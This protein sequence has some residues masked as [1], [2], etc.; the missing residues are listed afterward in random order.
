M[1]LSSGTPIS[2]SLLAPRTT[3]PF[4]SAT[5]PDG[6]PSCVGL[7]GMA[8]PWSCRG[9]GRA[10]AVL[11][12]LTSSRRRCPR[13]YADGPSPFCCD[14]LGFLFTG[15][16][17]LPRLPPEARSSGSPLTSAGAFMFCS[18]CSVSHRDLNPLRTAPMLGAHT[19]SLLTP[20]P[21]RVQSAMTTPLSARSRSLAPWQ[22]SGDL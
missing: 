13:A 17:V 5:K 21:P 9:R 2:L 14:S 1:S 6:W 18:S 4:T 10:V 8:A 12:Q 16:R 3:A 7:C 22:G 19:A 11:C 20:T 15:S